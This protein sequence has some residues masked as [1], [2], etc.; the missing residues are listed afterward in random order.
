MVSGAQQGRLLHSLVRLASAK[1]VLEVGC[2]T[3]YAT[4]WMALALPPGGRLL[5]LE[6]D[7]RAAEVAV[8]HLA[9]GGVSDRTEVRLGD[10]LASLSALPADEPPF[11]LIV[12]HGPSAQHFTSASRSPPVTRSPPVDPLVCWD[13]LDP[14]VDIAECGATFVGLPL[15]RLLA[16]LS[17]RGVLVLVDPACAVDQVQSEAWKTILCADRSLSVVTVPS[18]DGDGALLS[19]VSNATPSLYA[20]GK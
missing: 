15:P 19:L 17:P 13:P 5:S 8:R 7:A 4:L 11:D 18:P 1:R 2:F 10:A 12:W 16:I 3:G 14:A 6:R 20:T 9:A